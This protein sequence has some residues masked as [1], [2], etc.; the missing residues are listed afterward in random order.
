MYV[1]THI[2]APIGCS[3]VAMP[4][5]TILDWLHGSQTAGRVLVAAYLPWDCLRSWEGCF[6]AFDTGSGRGM[7]VG[8]IWDGCGLLLSVEDGGLHARMWG[9][10]IALWFLGKWAH[11]LI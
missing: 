9:L 1:H 8:W 4:L 11:G 7:G 10:S 6:S 5:C 3:V 2:H